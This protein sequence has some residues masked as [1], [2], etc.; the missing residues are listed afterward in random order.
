MHQQFLGGGK[1][2]ANDAPQL[3]FGSQHS[4]RPPTTAHHLSHCTAN[5]VMHFHNAQA[6]ACSSWGTQIYGTTTTSP[7][8]LSFATYVLN[9]YVGP[10]LS[11]AAA[12][13]RDAE[14]PLA[15]PPY[16]TCISVHT[17]KCQVCWYKNAEKLY[18][19]NRCSWTICTPCLRQVNNTFFHKG[20]R[21]MLDQNSVIGHQAVFHRPT[22]EREQPASA[23]AC[24]RRRRPPSIKYEVGVEDDGD[25]D[26][27]NITPQPSEQSHRGL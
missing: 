11:A 16:F 2:P 8:H 26:L 19:C 4:S 10:P 20:C 13:A 22:Y 21:Y 23:R 17:A 25:G 6:E 1:D 3:A 27:Q 7:H 18:R 5:S 9:T 15:M 24:R 14:R 12:P